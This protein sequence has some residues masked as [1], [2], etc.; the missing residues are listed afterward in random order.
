[1]RDNNLGFQERYG[2]YGKQVVF[3]AFQQLGVMAT[4]PQ[5]VHHVITCRAETRSNND[6]TSH[7]TS[8]LKAADLEE[9]MGIN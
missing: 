7:K 1:M 8:K 6:G 3:Y 2:K 5:V 9:K 4:S